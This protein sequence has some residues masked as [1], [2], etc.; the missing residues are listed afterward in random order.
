[1]LS[2]LRIPVAQ[3]PPSKRYRAL[4]L[5]REPKK[6]APLLPKCALLVRLCAGGSL[7][8]CKLSEQRLGLLPVL[9]ID[10]RPEYLGWCGNKV[11]VYHSARKH[12]MF[13]ALRK[14]D[15]RLEGPFKLAAQLE[16]GWLVP[17][18]DYPA[19]V[20]VLQGGVKH[21]HSDLNIMFQILRAKFPGRRIFVLASPPC[22]MISTC[23]SGEDE[24]D[25]QEYLQGSRKFLERLRYS[26]DCRLV[27]RI[28]VECSAPGRWV[29]KATGRT[30]LPGRHAQTMLDA[31]GPGF[32]VQ[33]LEA[34]KWGSPSRR[35]RL[36]FAE[37][38]VFD[39]LPAE[40]PE[41]LWRGWGP[42]VGVCK[43]SKGRLVE[44]SWRRS[45]DIGFAG[46]FPSF[47]A[48]CI[49]TMGLDEYYDED[50]DPTPTCVRL[51]VV[52]LAK[53]L[54]CD[55]YDP[56]LECLAKMKQGLATRIVGIG[57]SPQWYNAA[58]VAQLAECDVSEGKPSAQAR[59]NASALYWELE[60]WRRSRHP[61]PKPGKWPKEHKLRVK[62]KDKEERRK[63]RK[64]RKKK[65]EEQKSKKS[66]KSKKN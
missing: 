6:D 48:P 17:G 1:M 63:R 37:R 16:K 33:K 2:T 26:K 47:P 35:N 20:G 64:K 25:L 62:L 8:C 61:P 18:V 3:L 14:H 42:C 57:F 22:R 19:G 44:V 39:Y 46:Q 7:G 24:G 5:K 13:E 11:H 23:N 54:G 56:R 65:R 41:E 45:D 49:T 30:F 4:Q 38:D 29:T 50:D 66:K 12:D 34:A 27:D 40:L 52:S 53:V 31:L 43:N 55:A 15:P 60:N 9:D 58:M 28:M 32:S 10:I 36:L 21:V 51:G 59:G